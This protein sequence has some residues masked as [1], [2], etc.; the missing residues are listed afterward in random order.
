MPFR[1]RQSTLFG[2]THFHA[3]SYASSCHPKNL[4][5]TAGSMTFDNLM[6]T[7]FASGF[8]LQCCSA[9]FS[10]RSL[11]S[12]YDDSGRSTDSVTGNE[13]GSCGWKGSPSTVSED[14]RAML[15]MPSTRQ[16]SRT[17]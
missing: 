16:A 11:L 6:L 15:V 2:E 14:A 8:H 5:Y 9:I 7:I 3:R 12:E 10:P 1:G 4:P 13:V 17:L